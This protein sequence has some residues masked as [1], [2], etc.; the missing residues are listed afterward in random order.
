MA[1]CA[2]E[3]AIEVL[4]T[5]GIEYH[6]LRETWV[7][8]E[9]LGSKSLIAGVAGAGVTLDAM[10]SNDRFAYTRPWHAVRILTL[11]QRFRAAV[12][13]VM[14]PG[15]YRPSKQTIAE[16]M[17]EAASLAL[18]AGLHVQ[19]LWGKNFEGH[20]LKA[21]AAVKSP[22]RGGEARRAQT[23]LETD[24]VLEAMAPLVAKPMSAAAA[25]RIVAKN[26]IGTSAKANRAL[27]QRYRGPQKSC[28][29]ALRCYNSAPQLQGIR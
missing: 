19:A 18:D 24:R 7:V 13:V 3:V 8:E 12:S 23:Q 29:S 27:W 28:N 6:G 9:P 10:A 25:A 14:G 22:I 5:A 2:E 11:C 26:G 16:H 17:G 1:H 4:R 15:Q 20:V 21:I